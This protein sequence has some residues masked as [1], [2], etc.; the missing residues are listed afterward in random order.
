MISADV[1]QGRLS[2]QGIA[3]DSWRK[4]LLQALAMTRVLCRTRYAIDL[5][6]GYYSIMT[7]FDGIG[8]GKQR[9]LKSAVDQNIV[10]HPA[11]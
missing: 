3:T 5:D 4:A 1:K 2:V 11:T 10:R 9:R 7:R 8:P 6:K